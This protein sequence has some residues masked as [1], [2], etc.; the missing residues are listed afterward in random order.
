MADLIAAGDQSGWAL[1]S[2][3]AIPLRCGQ[4]IDVPEIMLKGTLLELSIENGQA[5]KMFTPG[6]IMSGFRIPGLIVLG[7]LEE[8]E[9]TWGAFGLFPITVPWKKILA[10]AA[11]LVEFM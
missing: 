3:A 9:A 7:P 1:F 6:P 8:K 4:D 5:A 11:D 2:K 10:L